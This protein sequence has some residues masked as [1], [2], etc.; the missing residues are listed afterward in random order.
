VLSDAGLIYCLGVSPGSIIRNNVFHDM[1]PYSNPAFGWGIYL[2]ATCGQ[3]LVESNLVYNTRSGGLMYNN[4][5][6][7]HVIQNN[8]FAL[9]ANHQLWPFYEK[10]PNT[11]RRNIV[12]LTQGEL[13]IPYGEKSLKERLA[14]KESL[15][16]WDEN[17]YWNSAGPDRLRFCGRTF[18]EWQ[19]LGLDRHSRIVDP[20]FVNV[21]KADFRLK[22]GSPAR[23]IGFGEIDVSHA[24]LY[25]EAAWKQECQ[26][27]NCRLAPLP[28]P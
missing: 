27:A 8:I 2:D 23:Q 17:L 19:E 13:F 21:E 16:F 15:G 14:A 10:R 3:Y 18:A 9:S 20:D 28:L 5:G 4:G 25:G 1:W 6:H 26:H 7:E 24:G 12:Y 11:F 22:G